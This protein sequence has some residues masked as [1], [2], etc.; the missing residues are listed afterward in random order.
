[1]YSNTGMRTVN[2]SK[3]FENEHDPNILDCSYMFYNCPELTTVTGILL[4]NQHIV[5][6]VRFRSMFENCSKLTTISAIFGNKT[7]L[8]D[9]TRMFT[10]CDITNIPN[11][12]FKY[13]YEGTEVNIPTEMF[14]NNIHL[15][16]Y[17]IVN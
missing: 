3:I 11:L 5:N 2:I 1:M 4:V 8:P 12:I 10:N 7:L 6:D 17:P 14:A 15:V 16:N 9:M 13:T